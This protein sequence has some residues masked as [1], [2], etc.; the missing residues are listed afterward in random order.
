MPESSRARKKGPASR[1]RSHART[2]GPAG[3]PAARSGASR[4]RGS[5]KA[6][7]ARSDMKPAAASAVIDPAVPGGGRLTRLASTSTPVSTTGPCGS[8]PTIP[9]EAPREPAS[10]SALAALSS[11]LRAP[12]ICSFFPRPRR[13][14]GS[15]ALS[16]ASARSIARQWALTRATAPCCASDGIVGPDCGRGRLP[17]AR[18]FK[19]RTA[20]RVSASSAWRREARARVLA[21]DP[22]DHPSPPHG[23]G[24]GKSGGAC[25]ALPPPGGTK[26]GPDFASRAG[27]VDSSCLHAMRVAVACVGPLG[28]A[29]ARS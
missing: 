18:K 8:A 17:P 28:P 12:S 14:R 4:I 19:A 20:E 6:A 3:G 29:P 24:S 11:S 1:T 10:G 13:R 2:R 16:W 22:C 21:E 7:A 15:T 27:T 23:T 9:R 25:A 26:P 5:K